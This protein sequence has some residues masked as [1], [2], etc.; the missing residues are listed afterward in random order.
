MPFFELESFVALSV[1]RP[2]C[3][4]RCSVR[5]LR[6]LSSPLSS[7]VGSP[8]YAGLRDFDM[9]LE[10]SN[11]AHEPIRPERIGLVELHAFQREWHRRIHLVNWD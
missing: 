10:N 2:N 4:V 8:L 11:C 5:G 3:V 1:V 9:L 6:I 7:R